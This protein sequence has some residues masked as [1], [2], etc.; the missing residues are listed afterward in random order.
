MIEEIA[1]DPKTR[2]GIARINGNRLSNL[3]L[4]FVE[5]P[6]VIIDAGELMMCLIQI[7]I[8]IKRPAKFLS[9]ECMGKMI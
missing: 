3:L 1:P 9:C 6:N 7:G 2:P 4:C 5:Q 8:Q